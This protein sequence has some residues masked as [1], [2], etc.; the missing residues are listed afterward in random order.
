MGC[1]TATGQHAVAG[2]VEGR[3]ARFSVHNLVVRAFKPSGV[4]I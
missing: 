2:G 4:A 3:L 1:D